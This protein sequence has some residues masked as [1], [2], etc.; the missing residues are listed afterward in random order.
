MTPR[1]PS[2]RS[3]THHSTR[4]QRWRILSSVSRA[5]RAAERL[6]PAQPQPP[7]QPGPTLC[8]ARVLPYQLL[9]LTLPPCPVL[10]HGAAVAPLPTGSG[11]CSAA[12]QSSTAPDTR[13]SGRAAFERC[14]EIFSSVAFSPAANCPGVARPYNSRCDTTTTNA[15]KP[16]STSGWSTR[17]SCTPRL[18]SSSSPPSPACAWSAGWR[19]RCCCTSTRCQVLLVPPCATRCRLLLRPR[20]ASGP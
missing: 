12:S 11:G 14:A 8:R 2:V 18:P 6:L 3:P 13:G 19:W 10:V 17:H 15:A 4:N 7:A 20:L 9:S 16:R 1:R 5:T